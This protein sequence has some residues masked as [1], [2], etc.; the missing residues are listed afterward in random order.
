MNHRNEDDW[1]DLSQS[2]RRVEPPVPAP[3]DIRRRLRR[4]R[5]RIVAVWVMD[6]VLAAGV[7][8][9]L[10]RELL[11]QPDPGNWILFTAVGIFLLV[12][13]AFSAMNRRGLWY[14]GDDTLQAYVAHGLKHCRRRLRTIRFAWWLYAAELVFF[15]GFGVTE[16]FSVGAWLFTGA[17]LAVFTI[18]FACWTWWFRNRVLAERDYLLGLTE[19]ADHGR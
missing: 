15:A 1:E 2:W 10:V 16:G 14:P 11:E 4:K 5:T 3:A 17:F 12:A 6:V 18:G 19:G 9:I 13:I 7:L 8:A